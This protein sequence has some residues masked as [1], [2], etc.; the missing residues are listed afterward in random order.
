MIVGTAGKA[1]GPIITVVML[2]VGLWVMPARAGSMP[3]VT[4]IVLP[5]NLVL[6]VCE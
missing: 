5:N 6:L 2:L 4:R 1:K 3:P